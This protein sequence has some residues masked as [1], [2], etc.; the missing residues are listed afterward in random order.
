MLEHAHPLIKVTIVPRG[1][2]LG[3]AWYQPHERQITIKEQLLDEMCSTLG[4]RASEEIMFERI[5]SGALNDLEKVTKQAYSMIAFLGMSEKVGNL[6][7]YDSSG[8]SEYSFQKPYSEKT[9]EL[10]DQEVKTLIE[11]QY[12]RAK[13]VI[14][15]NK[16]KLTELAELL[17]KNEVIFTEDLERILGKRNFDDEYEEEVKM[18]RQKNLERLKKNQEI[19]LKKEEEELKIKEIEDQINA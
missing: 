1:Q 7:F 4:G 12:I 17:L 16:D 11:D 15:E 18:Q 9:S 8:R 3:A 5:S 10:I 2:A 6:S 19:K 14:T 13:N